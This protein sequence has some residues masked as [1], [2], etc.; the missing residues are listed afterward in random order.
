[1]G[2][3]LMKQPHKNWIR[4]RLVDIGKTQTGLGLAIDLDKAQ[5]SRM[6][7][8]KRRVQLD[9]V[10]PMASYLKVETLEMLKRLGLNI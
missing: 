6:L 1:M 3:R 9:E 5:V 2:E 7:C 8:G 10:E 4:T